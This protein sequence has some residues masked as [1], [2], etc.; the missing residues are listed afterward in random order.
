M[1][2]ARYPHVA[3]RVFN[4]PLLI[5]PGKLD[6]IVA[7]LGER[8]LGAPLEGAG[9][10]LLTS[11]AGTWQRPGYRVLDG[12]VA[13]VDVFG[14]LAQRGRLEADS[15]YVQGYQDVARG[16]R[17]ALQDEAVRGVLLHLDTPGGEANGAFDLADLIAQANRVKPV[18]A[19][20]SD[21][22][23]SAG[24]LLAS[25]AGR[26]AVSQ[27]GSVGSIGVVMRHVDVSQA[28]A[29]QGVRVT[30]IQAGAKKSLG[31]PFEPL[32]ESARA[33]LQARVDAMYELFVRAV[34]ARRGVSEQAVRDT[35]AG[36]FAAEEAVRLGLADMVASADAMVEALRELVRGPHRTAA[37]VSVQVR[38]VRMSDE[39]VGL[40]TQTESSALPTRERDLALAVEQARAA[41]FEAGV[42]QERARVVAILTHEQARGREGLAQALVEQGIAAEQAA[43]ILAAAPAATAQENAFAQAM[44]AL[45]NP[46][47][48]PSEP[49][50]QGEKDSDEAFAARIAAKA[51]RMR[52][53][54]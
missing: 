32:S 40:S 50:E 38:S 54:K 23:L 51:L 8:L 26:V 47:V 27:S 1:F 4:T 25:A 44:R 24:Y 28:T 5:E 13:V 36:V 2:W 33:E 17:A 39:T 37:G 49:E 18:W 35:Q 9:A 21:L 31:N 45:G 16:L 20:A 7:G 48:S 3:A 41:G 30:H 19:V 22:A 12:G 10:R 14:L 46:Q 15:S 43:L 11:E 29:M 34:A 53:V 42:R 52:I 6:A